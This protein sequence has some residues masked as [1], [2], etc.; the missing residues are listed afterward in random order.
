MVVGK[1]PRALEKDLNTELMVLRSTNYIQA[2]M[3]LSTA[4]HPDLEREKWIRDIRLENKFYSVFQSTARLELN[5][6]ENRPMRKQIIALIQRYNQ[7]R[8]KHHETINT[9]VQILQELLKDV[10][11][12]IDFDEKVMEELYRISKERDFSPCLDSDNAEPYCLYSSEPTVLTMEPITEKTGE[13]EEEQSGGG[14]AVGKRGKLWLP[15]KNRVKD[16]ADNEKG[17]YVRLADELLRFPRIQNYLLFPTSYLSVQSTEYR[18]KPTEI[19]LLQSVLVPETPEDDYFKNSKPPAHTNSYV[20]ELPYEFSEPIKTQ[21]Y[22]NVISANHPLQKT[23]RKPVFTEAKKTV[24]KP[25]EEMGPGIEEPD[26]YGSQERSSSEQGEIVEQQRIIQEFK[27]FYDTC[28]S[29]TVSVIGSVNNS[30]WKRMFPKNTKELIYQGSS[31]TQSFCCIMNLI[32]SYLKRPLPLHEMKQQLIEAYR[33]WMTSVNSSVIE[34]KMRKI[35]SK[36]NSALVK[37]WKDTRDW[38]SMFLNEQYIFTELDFWV[39]S[40]NLQLPVVLFTSNSLKNLFPYQ[41]GIPPIK[42]L[43]LYPYRDIEKHYFIRP[44]SG[45]QTGDLAPVYHKIEPA[46]LLDSLKDAMESPLS[47]GQQIQE[48][49]N[50]SSSPYAKNVLSLETYLLMP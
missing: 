12:F 31:Q 24:E 49:L 50:Q 30:T 46:F 4:P 39:V 44:P 43:L 7:G 47:L 36:Y 15:K 32:Y 13:V 17:Y 40:Q 29:Q 11:S 27:T 3:A 48:G 2:D 26:E 33:P 42:W 25:R 22:S 16:T 35:L 18:I 23:A 34:K 28:I 1:K 19:I 20:K 37:Q 45:I 9:F 41:E 10:V 8:A 21:P 14:G 38:E 5:L 6:Y